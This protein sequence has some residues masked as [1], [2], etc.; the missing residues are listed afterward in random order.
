MLSEAEVARERN[1]GAV[2]APLHPANR[3]R[4]RVSLYFFA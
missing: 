1:S 4:E 2:E 3:K